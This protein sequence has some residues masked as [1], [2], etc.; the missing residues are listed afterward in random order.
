MQRDELGERKAMEGRELFMW[1][2]DRERERGKMQ[3]IRMMQ[4]KK[5]K[6]HLTES[7]WRERERVKTLRVLNKKSVLPTIDRKKGECFNITRFL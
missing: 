2:E 1:R 7:S 6:K 5:K 4:K 3:H